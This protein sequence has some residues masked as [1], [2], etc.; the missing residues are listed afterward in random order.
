MP[1]AGRTTIMGKHAAFLGKVGQLLVRRI[2][3]CIIII[4]SY[5]IRVATQAAVRKHGR[6]EALGRDKTQHSNHGWTLR[7]DQIGQSGSA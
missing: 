7:E 1:H 5:D 4:A 2:G 3:L 6:I